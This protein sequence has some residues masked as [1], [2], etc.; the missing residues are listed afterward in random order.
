M[1]KKG[2]NSQQPDMYTLNLTSERT[3]NGIFGYAFP[4]KAAIFFF[5]SSVS[6]LTV[7]VS[8]PIGNVN[9]MNK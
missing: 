2:E 7:V 4:K 8:W 9:K 1:A 6:L 5:G 3:E